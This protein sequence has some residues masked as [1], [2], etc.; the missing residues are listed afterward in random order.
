MAAA[1]NVMPLWA[2]HA[3][4][5]AVVSRRA[6]SAQ[7]SDLALLQLR[8]T[9]TRLLLA[10]MKVHYVSDVGRRNVRNV[11]REGCDYRDRAARRE[12]AN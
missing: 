4:D 2:R 1:A 6:T 7:L 5:Q 8:E 10:R 9:A 3:C 11:L 12:P